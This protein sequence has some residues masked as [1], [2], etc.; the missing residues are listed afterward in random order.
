MYKICA[1]SGHRNL[2]GYDFDPAL[3]DRV[4]ENLIK[5]GTENFLCG[6]ALGFDMA[7][8]ESVLQF[9]S[10]YG[11]KLTAVLPCKNQSENY[12]EANKARYQR[13]LDSCDE[14]IILSEEYYKGCMHARDRYLVENSNAVVCF[15]RKS[16]GGTFYTVSYAKKLNV[17]MIEL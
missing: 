10:K 6:M 9:K 12:S 4:V 2:K 14:V 11:V 5:T 13:I 16:G 17:P 1:F 15:L 3:L 8:A 7:A